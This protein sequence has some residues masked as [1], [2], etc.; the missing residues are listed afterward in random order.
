[1]FR[2]RSASHWVR[3]RVCSRSSRW[4]LSGMKLGVNN[5]C[6]KRSAI[7]VASFTS[8]LRPGTFFMCAGFTTHVV[9]PAL[10]RGFRWVSSR[11]PSLPWPMGHVLGLKRSLQVQELR[12]GRAK[13]LGRKRGVA[14]GHPCDTHRRSRCVYGHRACAMR[15]LSCRV[16]AGRGTG[17]ISNL[18]HVSTR[19]RRQSQVPE[20]PNTN[21]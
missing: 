13:G 5:P 17:P 9:N 14:L 4:G 19:R 1:M 2:A 21:S 10:P 6:R 16:P 18:P 3:W 15:V 20:A 7:P 12:R 11:S 8:V